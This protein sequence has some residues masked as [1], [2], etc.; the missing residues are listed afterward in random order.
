[1]PRNRN[2]G[3]NNIKQNI[4]DIK[5]NEMQFKI[6]KKKR[7]SEFGQRSLNFCSLKFVNVRAKKP[8]SQH[9]PMIVACKWHGPLAGRLAREEITGRWSPSTVQI[10][11]NYG[12]I[13]VH[14]SRE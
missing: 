9:H 2:A 11:R 14:E 13:L 10:Q 3:C 12:C 5:V 4:L 6:S 8:Y 7:Y 1:L